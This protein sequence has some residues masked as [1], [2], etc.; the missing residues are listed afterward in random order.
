MTRLALVMIVKDEARS[1]A[2]CLES[3]QAAVDRIVVV[4]TGSTDDTVEIA[5]RYG[6]E[7]H[8]HPWPNDFAAARNAALDKSDAD[9]N[10]VLDADEW[11]ESGAEALSAATL[12]AHSMRPPGFAG[13]VRISEAERSADEAGMRVFAARILPR[14]VRYAGRIHEQPVTDLP[15]TLLPI[16]VGHDG[17]GPA[18]LTRKHGR[19][20]TLLRAAIGESPQDPHL[21][22]HLGRQHYIENDHNE[23][24]N[25]LINAYNLGAPDDPIRLSLVVYT[26]VALRLA[27]RHEEALTLVDAEQ[28]NWDHAPDFFY[29]VAELYLEWAYRNPEAARDELLPVVETAWLKCLQIGER[30]GLA[31]SLEGAGS[32]RPAQQ[33][34]VFY[35]GLGFSEEAALFEQMSRDMRPAAKA[36]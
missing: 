8:H 9:W 13:C 6:A 31:G 16:V 24:A 4:D 7:I 18:Q 12:P 23:A 2:R 28:H 27:G 14:G 22:Y 29:A 19:N 10:L 3:V 32:Y 15:P 1:L 17:Y 36:A 34:A 20:Q 21:W 35:K 5:T 26:I 33:L 25:C 30:P 11:L